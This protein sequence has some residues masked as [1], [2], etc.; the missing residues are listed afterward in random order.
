[1][2]QTWNDLLFAHWPLEPDYVRQFV[3]QPLALDLYGG[4]AWLAVTPFH[5]TNVRPRWSPP[6]PWISQFPELNCRTYVAYNGTPGVFFFSL[7][8]ARLL[9][10]W[11]ARYTYLLPYFHAQMRV[12][13]ENE[14]VAYS[15]RRLKTPAEFRGRY[16][17]VGPVRRREKGALEYF[18]TERYC[19]FA[20]RGSRVFRGDIHH[21]PWPLQDAETEIEV[22]T[23]AQ[24]AGIQLPGVKPLLHFAKKLDVLIWPLRTVDRGEWLVGS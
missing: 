20:V 18:L 22:N 9:A 24:A 15:S 5:M 1:M 8:A 23:I 16:R 2:T 19:L 14:T 10:V 21:V 12:R 3:P 17:P 6:L 13:I 11:A 4:Q 7:D